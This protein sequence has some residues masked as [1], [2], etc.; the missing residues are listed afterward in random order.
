MINELVDQ[1]NTGELAEEDMKMMSFYMSGYVAYLRNDD[2]TF[3]LACPEESCKK[4]VIEESVGWR[5][6]NCN[7]TYPNCV[8]TYMLCAKISDVS[9]TLFIN[10]YRHEGTALMGL[11]ADKLRELKD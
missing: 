6:E 1:V 7:K 4:K 2:K 3:Y 10:F 5:C 8:P 9:D 11:P